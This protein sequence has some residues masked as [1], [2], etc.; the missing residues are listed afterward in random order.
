MLDQTEY[1]YST[2]YKLKSSLRMILAVVVL[3]KQVD[4]T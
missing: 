4:S 2:Q 1:G 3:T